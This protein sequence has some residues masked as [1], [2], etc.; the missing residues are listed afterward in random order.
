[1]MVY[2]AIDDTKTAGIGFNDRNRPGV[3]AAWLASGEERE[4]GRD[5]GRKDG[6][7]RV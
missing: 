2:W 6:S 7:Q 5:E 1:M 3:V 4:D